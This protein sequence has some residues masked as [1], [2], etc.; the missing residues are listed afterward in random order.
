MQQNQKY[1]N[2]AKVCLAQDLFLST[3]TAPSQPYFKQSPGIGRILF[4]VACLGIGLL[5]FFFCYIDAANT[6]KIANKLE[7]L[8]AAELK[9]VQPGD[10]VIIAGSLSAKNPA[11]FENYIYACSEEFDD[12][13][14]VTDDIFDQTL[15]LDKPY[16]AEIELSGCPYA[17]ISENASLRYLGLFK[18]DQL[19]VYGTVYDINPLA[20]N[21]EYY[22]A[23]DSLTDLKWQIGAQR[24]LWFWVIVI[25]YGV[26][27]IALLLPPKSDTDDDDDEHEAVDWE[28][29][30]TKV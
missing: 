24:L 15:L 22:V 17:N 18:G 19:T 23:S 21:A 27:L 9:N 4:A 1:A 30:G 8:T 29:Y 5:F 7:V 2:L 28:K 13:S 14:W 3:M 11:V 6:E 26:G 12:G 20:V 10:K 16:A 25:I